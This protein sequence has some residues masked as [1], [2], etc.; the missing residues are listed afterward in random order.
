MTSASELDFIQI[1]NCGDTPFL[2]LIIQ[3]YTKDKKNSH[4]TKSIA[5]DTNNT[6]TIITK[7]KNLT[8]KLVNQIKNSTV[9]EIK[10]KVNTHS[11]ED[12]LE[13]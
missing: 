7:E 2:T 11:Q 10:L 6:R 9:S 12:S 8:P 3:Y 13:L 4:D 5:N 1:K